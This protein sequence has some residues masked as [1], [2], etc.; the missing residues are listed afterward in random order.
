MQARAGSPFCGVLDALAPPCLTANVRRLTPQKYIK[1]LLII[2]GLGLASVGFSQTTNDYPK[3]S[4]KFAGYD[5]PDAALE[6]WAWAVIKGDKPVILKT[7]T[8]EARTEWEK[9]WAGK[10]DEQMKVEMSNEAAKFSGYTIKRRE[11]IAY[12]EVVVHLTI[13]GGDEIRKL[14][15]RKIGTDWKIAGPK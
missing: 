4:L 13:I 3:D 11:V 8:P 7:L 9:L 10:T 2:V 15:F 6:T 5:S 12:D 1:T 14:D